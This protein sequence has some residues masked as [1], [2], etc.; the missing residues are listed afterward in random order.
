MCVSFRSILIIVSL[1]E[2]SLLNSPLV[3][4]PSISKLLSVVEPLLNE[5]SPLSEAELNAFTRSTIA[6]SV[7]SNLF[8]HVKLAESDSITSED[9]RLQIA[10]NWDFGPE[11]VGENFYGGSSGSRAFDAAKFLIDLRQ[12]E[13][14]GM[15][16]A[17]FDLMIGIDEADAEKYPRFKPCLREILFVLDQ[18]D[19]ASPSDSDDDTPQVVLMAIDG[20]HTVYVYTPDLSSTVKSDIT[21]IAQKYDY[22]VF[23]H[24]HNLMLMPMPAKHPAAIKYTCLLPELSG[25]LEGADEGNWAH[26]L[27]S[28]NRGPIAAVAG[29]F[30][31]KTKSEIKK[32]LS[33][34]GIQSIFCSVEDLEDNGRLMAAVEGLNWHASLQ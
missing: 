5:L 3:S 10:Q 11:E 25:I 9:E 27:F 6:S 1:Q 17:L 21:S 8:A 16:L 19:L 4:R 29:T 20:K 30:D 23:F 13:Y 28:T 32:M 22:P 14:H 26:R 31:G 33:S 24:C 34:E 15:S 18:E 12:N 2:L 7:V